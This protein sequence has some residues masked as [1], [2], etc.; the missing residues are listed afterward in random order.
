MPPEQKD[1][2]MRGP[3][4]LQTGLPIR[5]PGKSNQRSRGS[6]KNHPWRYGKPSVNCWCTMNFM[7]WEMEEAISGTLFL[8]PTAMPKMG[9]T[10]KS[11]WPVQLS[12]ANCPFF[13]Q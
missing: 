7:L 4:D 9:C 8:W 5:L 3:E 6:T 11:N 1:Q 13:W 10:S 12:K 2:N